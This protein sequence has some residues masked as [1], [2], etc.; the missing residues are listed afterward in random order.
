MTAAGNEEIK[1]ALRAAGA[2]WPSFFLE[3]L[4][5]IVWGI[6][7]VVLLAIVDRWSERQ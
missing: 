5:G 6:V 3:T 7:L 1:Q 4:R 2:G